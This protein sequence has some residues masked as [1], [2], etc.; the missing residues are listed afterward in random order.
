MTHQSNTSSPALPAQSAYREHSVTEPKL[1]S[2]PPENRRRL[3]LT[4]EQA[5]A[6]AEWLARRGR[7]TYV[8][9]ALTSEMFPPQT[10]EQWFA[11]VRRREK[12]IIQ[13][14]FCVRS[15]SW[16][17]LWDEAGASTVFELLEDNEATPD[18]IRARVDQNL[19]SYALISPDVTW[20][21][22]AVEKAAL[23]QQGLASA[24]PPT[25]W[26]DALA[27]AYD[28]D[29]HWFKTHPGR[30]CYVRLA[31]LHEL[32]EA[33]TCTLWFRVVRQLEPGSHTYLDLECPHVPFS[34]E[35]LL[36]EEFAELM[37]ELGEKPDEIY[38]SVL[39]TIFE[40]EDQREAALLHHE[41]TE[42]REGLSCVNA[43]HS[44][45]SE[46]A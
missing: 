19:E 44:V 27:Q 42:A 34:T 29:C 38:C 15:V 12:T 4:L 3:E 5:C 31:L 26:V 36:S 32:P 7:L 11:V 17:Y 8:R 13:H 41:P 28:A 24:R 1:G 40:A 6:D 14:F 30:Q 45:G 21:S 10:G 35:L 25:K 46:V 33:P 43:S 37:I 22:E 9:R 23:D 2:L 16:S 39:T 18:Q 20:I